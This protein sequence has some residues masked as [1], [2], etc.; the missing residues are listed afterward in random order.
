MSDN[1][2]HIPIAHDNRA[3]VPAQLAQPVAAA[4][5]AERQVTAWLR[6]VAH[7]A[8]H[9]DKLHPDTGQPRPRRPLPLVTQDLME[10]TNPAAARYY[11]DDEWPLDE[12]INRGQWQS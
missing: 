1:T 8:R 10:I 3:L 2:T 7:R 12:G 5:G 11:V 6:D 9:D 4:E